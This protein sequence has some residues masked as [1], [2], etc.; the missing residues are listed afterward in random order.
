MLKRLVT[1]LNISFDK[2]V[3]PILTGVVH[4]CMYVV[5]KLSG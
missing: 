5:G 1:L 4:V 2:G 3:A